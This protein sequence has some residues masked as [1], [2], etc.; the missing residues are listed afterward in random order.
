M[1]LKK[2]KKFVKSMSTGFDADLKESIYKF[3]KVSQENGENIMLL[4]KVNIA[5]EHNVH[6]VQNF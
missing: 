4:R 5:E 6:R 2:L 3:F 1:A